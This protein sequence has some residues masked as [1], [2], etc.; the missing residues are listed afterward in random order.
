VPYDLHTGTWRS[1]YSAQARTAEEIM[2]DELARKMGKDP[3]A[4]RL[5]FLKTD[6]ERAVLNKV[7]SAGGWGR[8]MPPGTA[9]G[10]GF[11]A[12]YRSLAVCLAEI[13]CSTSTPRVTKAVVA[14]DVGLP[15][16]PTG[17]QAQAIGGVID[18]ISRSCPPGTTWT[19][20]PSVRAATRTSSTHGRRTHPCPARSMSCRRPGA[21][22]VVPVS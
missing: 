7:A 9:Q 2:V 8:L 6:T 3:V 21:V 14:V 18:G 5:E 15:V 12:E 1:V 17:L 4:F 20:A 13:D 22:R 10:V 11:H 16:N 19:T